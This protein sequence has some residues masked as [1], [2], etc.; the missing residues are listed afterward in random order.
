[1]MP[2]LQTSGEFADGGPVSGRQPF[3]R[4]QKLVLLRLNSVLSGLFF[5]EMQKLA[6][7]KPEFGYRLVVTWLNIVH[8]YIVTR[9]K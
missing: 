2:E 6:N 8:T 3:D 5:A 4:Q 1:M 7:L 9:Y